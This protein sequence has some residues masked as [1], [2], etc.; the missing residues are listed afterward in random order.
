VIRF[1]RQLPALSPASLNGINFSNDARLRFLTVSL[2]RNWRRLLRKR[3]LPI[4]GLSLAITVSVLVIL[5]REQIAALGVFGYPSVFLT[6]IILNSTVLNPIPMGW[7]YFSLGTI[8]HP[9]PLALVGGAGAAIGELTSYMTGRSGRILLEGKKWKFYAKVEKWLARW[10]VIVIFGLNLQ[11]VI[12]FDV[13]GLAAGSARFPLWKYYLAAM[14]GR[15]LAY[16]IIAYLGYRGY[17]PPLPFMQLS[18]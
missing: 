1:T 18:G 2:Q 3:V 5:H 10:G 15:S 4:L 12:P 8:F 13:A 11:P 14:A 17:I 6:S 7:I 16:G 9:V